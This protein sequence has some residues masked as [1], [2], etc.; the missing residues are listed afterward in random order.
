M[1]CLIS[2][3]IFTDSVAFT[4]LRDS[5]DEKVPGFKEEVRACVNSK[6]ECSVKAVKTHVTIKLAFSD[7]EAQ[8]MFVQ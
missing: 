2:E 8:L 3:N 6:V 1:L 4:R 7:G 5:L